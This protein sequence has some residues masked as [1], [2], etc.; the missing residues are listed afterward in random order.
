MGFFGAAHGWGG[1]AKRPP[2]PKICHTY[3]TM[4]KLGTVIPYPRK[5]QKIYKSRDTPLQFCWHQHFF[6]GNQHIL[7]YQE[8]QI[9][10]AFWYLISNSFNF[11]WVFKDCFDKH[12][13]K[14]DDASKNR[15]P[16]PSWNKGY[17]VII[18]VHD[19]LNKILSRDLNYIVDAVMWPKFGNCSISMRKVI[20]TSIL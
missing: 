20:I 18:F 6:T 5:I 7:I 1:V 14:F 19:V 9:Q 17:D 8:I 15:Y 16:R 13:Y 3:P 10:I 11:S 12:G 4:I 2:V